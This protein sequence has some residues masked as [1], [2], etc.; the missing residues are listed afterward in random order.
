MVDPRRIRQLLDRIAEEET[1]LH[2]LAEMDSEQLLA[3]HTRMHAV[4]YGFVVAIEAAWTP[5]GT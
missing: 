5:D 1:H 2:Q 3:D 4:K